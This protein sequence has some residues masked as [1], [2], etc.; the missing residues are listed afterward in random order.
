MSTTLY[1]NSL[2]RYR[3][4]DK[5]N[6]KQPNPFEFTIPS[7]E[8]NKWKWKMTPHALSAYKDHGGFD[9]ELDSVII[10]VS[11]MPTPESFIMYELNAS[12][13]NSDIGNMTKVLP[14]NALCQQIL[15]DCNCAGGLTGCCFTYSCAGV[16]GCTGVSGARLWA[17]CENSKKSSVKNTWVAHYE[18]ELRG[19]D[20]DILFYLYKSRG[21]VSLPYQVFGGG[22]LDVKILDSTGVQLVPPGIDCNLPC[23]YAHLFCAQNQIGA[24]FVAHFVP[25]RNT[26]Q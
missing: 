18:R 20:G 6:Q 7:T 16:S 13:L 5:C 26:C 21:I 2:V 4:S 9:V 3:E 12:G 1:I 23:N 19:S 24:T 10:P 15:G 8:T 11:I 25:V 14:N 17:P 22:Y